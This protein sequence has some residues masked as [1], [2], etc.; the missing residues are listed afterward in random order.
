[1]RLVSAPGRD[2]RGAERREARPEA[3]HQRGLLDG[4]ALDEALRLHG[5]QRRIEQVG[6]EA[7]QQT[8]AVLR[9]LVRGRRR[10]V[11]RDPCLV[12][13]DF[14]PHD[15]ARHAHPPANH[16][17]A[18]F[19]QLERHVVDGRQRAADELHRQVPAPADARRRRRQRHEPSADGGQRLVLRDDDGAALV[20]DRDRARQRVFAHQHAEDRG[21]VVH[22]HQLGVADDD[23]GNGARA[24]ERNQPQRNGRRRLTGQRHRRQHDDEGERPDARHEEHEFIVSNPEPRFTE[25]GRVHRFTGSQVHRFGLLGSRVHPVH[26]RSRVRARAASCTGA[27][28]E[29]AQVEDRGFD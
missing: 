6:L 22:R 28:D 12:A 3:D 18:G 9:D 27:V 11:Q 13:G 20:A 1:M 2:V 19:P 17:P 25:S 7:H 16:Q 21:Q 5:G 8:R 23:G 10:H 29:G 15:D 14:M 26:E 24:V 4:E